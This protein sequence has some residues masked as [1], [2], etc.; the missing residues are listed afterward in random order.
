[1]PRRCGWLPQP[2]SRTPAVLA[3]AAWS[4]WNSGVLRLEKGRSPRVGISFKRDS[5]K[6][7]HQRPWLLWP[8]RPGGPDSKTR[9]LTRM[10]ADVK[11][12]SDST[13]RHS[14]TTPPL[15]HKDTEPP[16]PQDPNNTWWRV[17]Q[18]GGNRKNPTFTLNRLFWKRSDLDAAKRYV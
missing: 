13:C 11:T 16:A 12:Y 18:R 6:V 5:N 9:D 14:P 4:R 2:Q 3:G 15:G 10:E 7:C 17:V 1:M 8:W